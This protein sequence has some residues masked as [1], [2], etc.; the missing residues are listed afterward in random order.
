MENL[1]VA[2]GFMALFAVFVFFALISIGIYVYMALAL[3]TIAKKT[4]TEPAWLAWIPIANF[5][6][7]AKIARV[8]WWTFL[9]FF[10]ALIPFVNI[11]GA[12]LFVGVTIWWWWRICERRAYPGWLA[13]LMLVP[14]ANLVIPGVVAWRDNG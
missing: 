4:R 2:G 5:Y 8:P 10:L 11:L 12:P 7:M 1:A 3:M 9:A 6:L 13:L 14:I